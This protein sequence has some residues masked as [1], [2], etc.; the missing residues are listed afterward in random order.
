[1]MNK[2]SCALTV[3]AALSL[4]VA[5]AQ[6][7]NEQ[8]EANSNTNLNLEQNRIKTITNSGSSCVCIPRYGCFHF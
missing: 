1:M 8:L 5:P 4:N 3:L 7:V 2:F 6:A